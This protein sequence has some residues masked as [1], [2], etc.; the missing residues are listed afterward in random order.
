MGELG[1]VRSYAYWSERHVREI[2]EA[3]DLK[4]DGRLSWKVK[5][6]AIPFL[7]SAELGWDARTKRRNAMTQVI[8]TAVG[9]RAV[10]DFVTPPPAQFAKGLGRVEFA[11]LAGAS[12]KRDTVVMHT[13]TQSSAGDRIEVCLFG[14]LKNTA[15]Y[16]G[17]GD[18]PPGGWPSSAAYAIDR[19]IRSH[20]TVNN[21]QWDDDESFA[22]EALKIATEQG[23]TGA[24]DE[25][26]GKPWSRGFTLGRTD[27]SEWFAK[28]Y[29]DTA[30]TKD[31]W[32]FDH[33]GIRPD[34]AR[35]LIGA[36]LWVRTPGPQA[37]TRY[38]LIR[39]GREAIPPLS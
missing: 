25:H 23:V 21:S 8:E 17:G 6:A 19:F 15:G 5:T 7:G 31:R 27:E 30:L 22:V 13:T 35:I 18:T 9:A 36:A 20:G 14:S 28:I 2:A 11:E 3:N 16:V 26:E 4:L 1:V 33:G 32:H 39:D 10:E 12:E 29:L 34:V 24:W 37:A 38:K